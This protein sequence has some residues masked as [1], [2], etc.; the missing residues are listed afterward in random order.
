MTESK[1]ITITCHAAL[2]QLLHD[3]EAPLPMIGG[4]YGD[5]VNE[6]AVIDDMRLAAATIRQLIKERDAAI[7]LA[8]DNK[9][10]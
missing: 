3:L 8:K 4:Y 1:D 9:N 6:D 7:V 2:Q 5:Y 10:A